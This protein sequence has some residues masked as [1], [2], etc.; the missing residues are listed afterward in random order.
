ML[1]RK[2]FKAFALKEL[3]KDEKTP[4]DVFWQIA[5]V[6]DLAHGIRDEQSTSALGA[7]ELPKT[8]EELAQLEDAL[9]EYAERAVDG[10]MFSAG[11]WALGKRRNPALVPFF[12]KALQKAVDDHR[13]GLFQAMCELDS[14]GEAIWPADYRSRGI[15]QVE[16]NVRFAKGYLASKTR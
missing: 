14:S 5:T 8:P 6:F 7:Y 16:D 9:V 12:I 15:D 1:E 3:A 4:E 10:R 11:L 13:E 2:P